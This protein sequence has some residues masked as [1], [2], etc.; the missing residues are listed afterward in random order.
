[1]GLIFVWSIAF[2][3]SNVNRNESKSQTKMVLKCLRSNSW[4]GKRTTLEFWALGV[5]HHTLRWIVKSSTKS[6]H[7]KG[8]LSDPEPIEDCLG[9]LRLWIQSLW[10]SVNYE[11]QECLEAPSVKRTL[12]L[13]EFAGDLYVP[14]GQCLVWILPIVRKTYFPLHGMKKHVWLKFCHNQVQVTLFV[15]LDSVG[16]LRTRHP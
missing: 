13:G 16:S 9:G 15:P 1:M 5:D 7:S 8:L 10:S 3:R 6:K 4:G 14:V 12:C 2:W 11:V